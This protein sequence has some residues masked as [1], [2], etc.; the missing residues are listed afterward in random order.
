MPGDPRFPPVVPIWDLDPYAGS[1][2]LVAPY[3]TQTARLDYVPSPGGGALDMPPGIGPDGL[4]IDGG[5]LVPP[6]G[7][8]V[9]PGGMPTGGTVTGSVW[10]AEA[11]RYANLIELNFTVTTTSQKF[12][13]A[14]DTYRNLLAF[15]NTSATANIYIGWGRDAS[16]ASVFRLEPDI[17]IL[18]DA[19][20]P[21]N[22]IYVIG[23]AAGSVSIAYSTIALPPR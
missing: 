5:G 21:Q 23:D 18:F 15:R 10:T 4:P 9:S 1:Q 11:H 19:V 14:P 20:V 12:L 7:G 6:G 17:M 22:D 8:L 16:T 3:G 13:D 2:Q